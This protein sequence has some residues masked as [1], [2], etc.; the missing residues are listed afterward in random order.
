MISIT[1]VA[2]NCNSWNR[3]DFTN[4]SEYDHECSSCSAYDNFSYVNKYSI[5][6]WEIHIP[7]DWQYGEWDDIKLSPTLVQVVLIKCNLCGEMHRVY[8][9]FILKGT[10]LTLSALIFI[11]FIYESSDFTW[12]DIPDK[13]CDAKDKIAHSTLFKAVQGLGK[14]LE[15]N[16]NIKESVA[17]LSSRYSS[18]ALVEES[19]PAWPAEKSRYEHT[20]TREHTL[21]ATLLPLLHFKPRY[22][23]L[24]S[25]FFKYLRPLRTI[26]SALSPPISSLT[27]R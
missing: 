21:R 15:A 17:E 12:R 9:S 1:I 23:T 25:F 26:L 24:T 18:S 19:N 13:L 7:Y 14:S 5:W 27:Y 4:I 2:E 16:D 11:T 6:R 8:P 3:R 22:D 10:T 20:L